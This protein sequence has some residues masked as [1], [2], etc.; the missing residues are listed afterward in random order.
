MILTKGKKIKKLLI[1]ISKILKILI[2][3]INYYHL[4]ENKDKYF[5]YENQNK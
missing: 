2:Q 5:S 3:N 1:I 4:F